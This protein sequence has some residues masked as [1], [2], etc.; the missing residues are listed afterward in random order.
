MKENKLFRLLRSLSAEEWNAFE[1]FIE[2]PYFNNGRNFL[3]L[4][5]YLKVSILKKGKE[6]F[7]AEVIYDKLYPGKKFNKS[8]VNTIVSNFTKLTENF[9]VQIEFDSSANPK[10][11]ALLKQLNHRNCDSLFEKAAALVSKH[12]RETAFDIDTLEYLKGLQENLVRAKYKTNFD[13]SIEN[14]IHKRSDYRFFVFYLWLLNEERDLRIMKD[15]MNKKPAERISTKLAKSINP[16]NV[17]SYI[18]EHYPE[19]KDTVGAIILYFTS[20]DIKRVSDSLYKN[21]LLFQ[22]NL[23]LTL[24]YILEGLIVDNITEGRKEELAERFR[25]LRFI[26]EKGL[27]VNEYQTRLNTR[28]TENIIYVSLWCKEFSWLKHFLDTYSSRFAE[29]MKENLVKYCRACLLFSEKKYAEALREL[30]LVGDTSITMKLR[31][32]DLELQLLFEM[33]KIDEVYF[34]IDNYNKLKLNQLVSERHRAAMD[35]NISA[36]KFLVNLRDAK[37]PG[38]S[39]MAAKS[40]ESAPPTQLGDWIL[41]KLK[42]PVHVS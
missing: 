18:E 35:V 36:Y 30:Y 10:K 31:M 37:N 25:L 11:L 32:K 8:V 33:N 13:K 9:L 1:K 19:L 34:A 7:E 26:L 15:V 24:F 20:R 40:L 4:F 17:I 39:A 38:E 22:P 27:V 12:A 28:V 23:A 16:E 6:S 2:S 21:Y 29:D 3:P 14:E 42:S 41:E 5:R